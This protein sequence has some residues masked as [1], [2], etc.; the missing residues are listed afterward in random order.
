MKLRLLVT[1]V[2]IRQYRALGQLG[3]T[4]KEVYHK[5]YCPLL[6]TTRVQCTGVMAGKAE[7]KE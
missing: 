5:S 3:A 7:L 6:I 2:L 4:P 1:R